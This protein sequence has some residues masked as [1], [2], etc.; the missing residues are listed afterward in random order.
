MSDQGNDRQMHIDVWGSK[1]S[2][3][4]RAYLHIEMM[5]LSD[6]QLHEFM[7]PDQ[8]AQY[9]AFIAASKEEKGE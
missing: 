6:A 4:E 7:T 8:F 5:G 9:K 3:L 2:A 1:L